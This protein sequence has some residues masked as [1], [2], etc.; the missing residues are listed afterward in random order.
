[1]CVDRPLDR[2]RELAPEI[3]AAAVEIEQQRRL[4]EALLAKLLDAGLFRLLLPRPFAG[5][6]VDPLT[7]VEV[8][9]EIA[10]H[11]ASTAWALCQT[12]V[13]AMAAAYLP[14]EA[15]Q[16]IFGDR[17]AVLAWGSGAN[18]K[19]VPV[20]GGYR[21]TGSWWFASGG[22]H[23]TWLGGHSLIC[24]PDGTPQRT[25]DGAVI[26]RTLLFPAAAAPMQD[27]WHVMGLKG[28]GSD[29]Y[30]V[31][32][33]FVPA[34]HAFGRDDPADRRYH[35]PLYLLKTDTMFS[36]GFAGLA[37]GVARAMLDALRGL[38]LEKT[39]RGYRHTLREGAVFQ[40]EFAEMD[41][42][43]GA[44][45][46][47]LV[48]TLAALWR[49][50][51]DTGALALDHRMALRLASTHAIREAKHVADDAYNA[52]GATAIFASHPFE[53][54]FRDINSVAQQLQARRSH[55]ETVGKFLLGLDAD[56]ATL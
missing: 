10:K 49:A 14:T 21:L 23:A 32:D 16:A 17:R 46:A 52:A 7:F 27:V 42:R 24:Q 12:S 40:T 38:A 54:R 3:A 11:D 36:A 35:A 8:V 56:T 15:A 18:G 26:A 45:R 20:G 25:A 4:P 13:C 19:A 1:M 44:A 34:A 2:A 6:E 43:L 50:V 9:E 53:R 47:Y 5:G 39:P 55:F 31:T 29:A 37:L 41:A 28:T 48:S 22:R 51:L 30:A 33:V